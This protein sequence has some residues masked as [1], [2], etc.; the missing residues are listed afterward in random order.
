MSYFKLLIKTI[1]DFL[2]NFINKRTW[3]STTLLFIIIFFIFSPINLLLGIFAML[4]S[5]FLIW[6]KQK[7]YA[8]E[9]GTWSE[10]QGNDHILGA[11]GI[12]FI[13]NLLI[14][15]VITQM[16]SINYELISDK[17]VLKKNLIYKSSDNSKYI[18]VKIK[19]DTYKISVLGCKVGNKINL[20]KK[21]RKNSYFNFDMFSKYVFDCDNINK[22]E[23][24][25]NF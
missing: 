5:S 25:V 24:V 4:I 20:Y 22:K 13:F 17:F 14:Y 10:I 8:K 15:I 16:S 6:V 23:K 9:N 7:K 12:A 11:F 18:N 2:N 19:G 21:T 1:F 3:W